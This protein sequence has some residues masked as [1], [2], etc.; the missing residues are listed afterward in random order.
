MLPEYHRARQPS[1]Q[2][3]RPRHKHSNSLLTPR[4]FGRDLSRSALVARDDS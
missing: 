3:P 2:A 4:V 1:S